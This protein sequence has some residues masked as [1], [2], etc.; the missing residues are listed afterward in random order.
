ME[1]RSQE[2]EG[3]ILAVF[4]MSAPSDLS[5]SGGTC[6]DPFKA[7]TSVTRLPWAV[8][9][10]STPPSSQVRIS[11][12]PHGDWRLSTNITLHT[13]NEH[14]FPTSDCISR[15]KRP[16]PTC[17]CCPR[18]FWNQLA[19]L[20]PALWEYFPQ[21]GSLAHPGVIFVCSS[22]GM[23]S[24][25]VARLSWEPSQVIMLAESLASQCLDAHKR[26]QGDLV[27]GEMPGTHARPDAF[28]AKPQREQNRHLRCPLP[29]VSGF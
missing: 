20:S 29:Q 2:A 1:I 16:S 25:S 10:H 9:F 23:R 28:V 7:S 27:C 13:D 4:H 18:C 3:L 14:R 22:E 5:F 6:S 26:T 12:I 24:M 8:H 17:M 21:S 15:Y 19:S 11:V